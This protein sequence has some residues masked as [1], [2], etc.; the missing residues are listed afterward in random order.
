M[1]WWKLGHKTMEEFGQKRPFLHCAALAYYAVLAIIPVI[2]LSV[3]YYGYLFGKDQVVQLFG[4]ILHE[5]VGIH[6]VTSF[7][8]ML[9]Q[10]DVEKSNVFL[11]IVGA[12][13]LLFSASTML[14]SI[15]KSL[16]EFYNVEISQMRRR[17]KLLKSVLSRLLYMGLL[18]VLT[19]LVISGFFIETVLLNY[20]DESWG[21]SGSIGLLLHYIFP[22]ILN[23]ALF[24]LIFKFLSDG[25]IAWRFAIKGGIFTGGLMYIG[26]I[27]IKYYLSHYFILAAGGVSASFLILLVWVFYSSIIF[28]LGAQF[29][30]TYAEVIGEPIK[31]RAFQL[32]K[33]QKA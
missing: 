22:V 21:A 17:E 26:Q 25:V 2:Y 9:H 28:F 20:I 12:L 27:L 24:T 4:I 7:E 8:S 5:E 23:V 33:K 15:R 13:V 18:I 1:N 32:V 6:D 11:E 31:E 10:I 16:N 14:N 3:S 30:A 19:I 29:I